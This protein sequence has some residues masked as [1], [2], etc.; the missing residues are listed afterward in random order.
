MSALGAESIAQPI[1][2][3]LTTVWGYVPNILAAAI[4]LVIG[5]LIAKLVRQLLIPVFSRIRVDKL[6]EKAGIQVPEVAKLSNTLAYLVYVLILIPVII[7]ALQVLNIRAISEPAISTLGMVFDFIPNIIVAALIIGVGA[8]IGKF[9][10]QIV[11]RLIAATGVDQKLTELTDGK[12]ERF[13]LSKVVGVAVEVV[14]IVF[15]CV[16]GLSVLQ[17][18]VLTGI[19]TAVIG[20]LPNVLASLIILVVAVFVARMAEKALKKTGFDAYTLLV[21]IAIFAIAAFMILNQLGI[22]SKIVNSAFILILAA[23]AVAFAVAFGIGGREFAANTLKK[24]SDK[25]ECAEVEETE[26]KP[27]EE[28]AEKADEE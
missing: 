8:I 17:L 20:Y 19:G 13:V 4:V 1:L 2:N 21:R 5:F 22:A 11:K 14:I 25:A 7:V 12:T 27:E 6:Q 23:L 16:E 15:F 28:P 26:E 18:S 9:A 24:L 10:G 3:L